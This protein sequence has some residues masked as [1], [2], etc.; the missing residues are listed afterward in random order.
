MRELDPKIGVQEE[1]FNQIYK[2]LQGDVTFQIRRMCVGNGGDIGYR[3]LM[4]GSSLKVQQDILPDLYAICEEVKVKLGYNDNIDFYIFGDNTVNARAWATDDEE[5]PHIITINS[6][7][8]N[9]MNDEEL[10]YI[11]GHEI[12]HLINKDAVI[13]DI[14]NFIYQDEAAKEDCPQFLKKRIELYNQLSELGADRYGYMANENLEACV[15]AIF[16]LASGLHIDKMNVSVEALI[17]ENANRLNYFLK[18]GGVSEG[19]H[20]VNPIRIQ[21]LDLFANA[22]TQTALNRGMDEL[23]NVLQTFWYKATDPYMADF[24]AAASIIVSRMDGR[25]DKFEEECIIDELGKFS[26][27]PYKDLK[28]VEKDDVQKVFNDSV[29]KIL[30]INPSMDEELLRYFIKVVIADGI[31]DEGEMGLIFNFGQ[32]LGFTDGE[33]AT[34][35]GIKLKED[36]APTALALK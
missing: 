23:I 31:L 17:N 15:T 35:V 14:Y 4:E 2:V 30:E 13:T 22:K 24:V 3:S 16:K 10:K 19:S 9:L 21:A 33:I 7:L 20:P 1:L 26:F 28:R 5:R 32:K 34:A 27:R 12:G 29:D 36:F 8:Y 18:D 6:G 25:V 11:I